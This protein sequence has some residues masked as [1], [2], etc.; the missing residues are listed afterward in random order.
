MLL[1]L[2][3][4]VLL[5]G[6]WDNYRYLNLGRAIYQGNG[7]VQLD[8]PEYPPETTISPGYP[9]L[10]AMIMEIAGHSRPLL[11][12][13]AFNTLCYALSIFLTAWISVRF[14][15]LNRMIAVMVSLYLATNI[16]TSAFASII[17]T[18]SP[19]I[20]FSTITIL[21]LMA[22]GE[23]HK[24]GWLAGAAVF[25]ALAIYVRFPGLPLAV[26]GF[27]WLL[28]H[29]RFKAACLYAGIVGTLLGIWVVP[30]LNSGDFGY[31][32][33]LTAKG[34]DY[35]TPPFDS[36]WQRYGH[37]L[38]GY[39][40]DHIPQRILPG[41]FLDTPANGKTLLPALSAIPAINYLNGPCKITIIALFLGET[42]AWARARDCSLIVL[43]PL[44]YLLMISAAASYWGRYV[45]YILPW[46]FLTCILGSGR[47]MHAL[48]LKTN[49][50]R[51]VGILA[52]AFIF[53]SI[54]PHYA[55]RVRETGFHRG[56]LMAL[57][58]QLKQEQDNQLTS[59]SA[60]S[61]PIP[62]N[63]LPAETCLVSN[64]LGGAHPYLVT[65]AF[66]WCRDNLPPHS[67]LMG[68]QTALGCFHAERPMQLLPYWWCKF[69][70]DHPRAILPE[71]NEWVWR[72]VLRQNATHLVMNLDDPADPCNHYMVQA[73]N[74]FPDC[75]QPIHIFGAPPAAAVILKI[76]TE[77]LKN[78]LQNRN[79]EDMPE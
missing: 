18:H 52:F 62:W 53:A 72:E 12:M 43:Y 57:S 22:Y 19:F 29:K 5:N 38:F 44:V 8:V 24:V 59:S 63:A 56:Q 2:S 3:F 68:C 34:C 69:S 74:A 9:F 71:S 66:R 77:L 46:I 47:L 6:T 33:Q 13:K 76:D 10:L 32:Q 55:H 17:F 11:A 1:Y 7:F 15:K 20:L 28:F 48:G 60:I 36:L 25:T 64:T 51:L 58:R 45:N 35:P 21:M 37:H 49:T 61:K 40:V 31:L 70:W 67:S 75:F 14:L 78:T 39:A 26:A 16:T 42:L 79:V 23:N 50:R 4:N 73:V 65:G 41:L 30:L 54:L 27:I